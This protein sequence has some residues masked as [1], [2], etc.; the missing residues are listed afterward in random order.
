M[1]MPARPS[2]AFASCRH[3]FLFSGSPPN[4]L[5]LLARAAPLW[6][7]FLYPTLCYCSSSPWPAPLQLFL[8]CLVPPPWCSGYHY[9][10]LCIFS[11]G[12]PPWWRTFATPSLAAC[13]PR[14]H[15]FFGRPSAGSPLFPGPASRGR[16]SRLNTLRPPGALTAPP[17][18]LPAPPGALP[19]PPG[20]LPAPPG[21]LP[22][23]P[24]PW[25]PPRLRWLAPRTSRRAPLLLFLSGPA[26]G[27]R[28][29]SLTR[30]EM[31]PL[32]LTGGSLLCPLSEQALQWVMRLAEL[33]QSPTTR[34][35]RCVFCGSACRATIC[36]PPWL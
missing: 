30:W 1:A 14:S 9:R 16:L 19:A 3:P 25:M 28:L 18:A 35:R 7:L 5:H 15:D 26:R 32:T 6:R 27:R 2:A 34:W 23:P 31:A 24:Q 8:S 21:A 29:V 33:W 22:L 17:G 11:S 4:H 13:S 36:A 12:L 20:A 10:L